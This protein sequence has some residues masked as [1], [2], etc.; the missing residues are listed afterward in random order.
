MAANSMSQRHQSVQAN[1]SLAVMAKGLG[2]LVSNSKVRGSIP[3]VDLVTE[4]A[5]R[6]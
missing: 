1:H 6:K 3:T 4:I 5:L 2:S